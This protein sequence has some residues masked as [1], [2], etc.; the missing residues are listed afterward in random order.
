MTYVLCVAV[1]IGDNEV[2]ATV[3]V[4][5]VNTCSRRWVDNATSYAFDG[6]QRIPYYLNAADGI[7]LIYDAVIGTQKQIPCDELT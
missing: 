2:A 7:T 4:G 1:R 6:V 5:G 3:D